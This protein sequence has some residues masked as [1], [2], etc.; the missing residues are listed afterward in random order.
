MSI[1]GHSYFAWLLSKLN[2]NCVYWALGLPSQMYDWERNSIE[3]E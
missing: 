2:C 3:V 1:F